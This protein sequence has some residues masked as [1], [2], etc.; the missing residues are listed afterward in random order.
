MR[1]LALGGN[2]REL[3]PALVRPRSKPVRVSLPDPLANGGNLRARL[4]LRIKECRE[5]VRHHV[6]RAEPD[7]RVFVDL[8]AE[9]TGA[10]RSLFANDFRGLIETRI[11]DEQGAAL[12]TGDV[13]CLVKAL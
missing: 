4:E 8:S 3:H 1:L 6:T 2:G 7:P 10:V 9:K 11:V 13:F 5:K 12:T